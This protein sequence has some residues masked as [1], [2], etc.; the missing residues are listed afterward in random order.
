MSV[1]TTGRL[2]NLRHGDGEHAG[3]GA[4]VE[5]AGEAARAHQAV[6]DDQRAGR[7]RM[8]AGAEGLARVDP[9]RDPSPRDAVA[10]VAAVDEEAAGRDGL[11]RFRPAPTQSASGRASTLSGAPKASA[12]SRSRS[13]SAISSG[14]PISK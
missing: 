11:Q 12:P 6:E 4:E 10:V 14:R 7:G 13:L 2:Q 3:A 8:V 9:N 5:R 1:A